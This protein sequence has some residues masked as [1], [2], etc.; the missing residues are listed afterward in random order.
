MSCI[1]THLAATNPLTIKIV[2]KILQQN[3][4]H[5]QAHCALTPLLAT[6]SLERL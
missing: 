3:V 2:H 6:K 5:K 1:P 4:G